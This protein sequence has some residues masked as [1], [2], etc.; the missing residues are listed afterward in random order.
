[1]RIDGYD[2][3]LDNGFTRKI[4]K[5]L[6]DL[7]GEALESDLTSVTAAVSVHSVRYIYSILH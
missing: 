2:G 1:M 5:N 7:R 6:R 4:D 3:E